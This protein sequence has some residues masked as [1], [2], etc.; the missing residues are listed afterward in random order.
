MSEHNTI[1]P[2]TPAISSAAEP[3]VLNTTNTQPPALYT[4]GLQRLPIQY[5]LSVGAVDDPMEQ[6]A[7][8][9]ADKI[10]RMPENNFIQRKC[11]H[12]EEEEKDKVR[13][14]PLAAFI[15]RKSGD[16]NKAVSNTVSEGIAATRGN[17]SAL[18]A[19]TQSFMENRFGTDF[20]NVNIHTDTPAVRLSAELGAK[21]FTIG[22]DI[23]FNEGK[24]SPESDSGK[25]LL[26]HELTHVIQQQGGAGNGMVQRA[27]VDDR[28]CAG[29]TDIETDINTLVNAEIAAARTA[30]GPAPLSPAAIVGL[31]RDVETRLG[32]GAVSPI[33]HFIEALPA[34]KRNLPNS[35]LTGNK[36]EGAGSANNFYRLQTLGLAHVVGSSAKMHGLC[37]GA[38]KLGH[39]FEEGF[40]YF[41]VAHRS[42][43]SVADAQSTGR[44]A[45]IGIQGLSST[46]VYSNADQAANLAGM[47]FYNDLLANPSGLTFSLASYITPQWNEQ[48]NPSFYESGVGTVVW[49]NLLRGN[50]QGPFT[51]AGGTGTPIDAKVTLAISSSG[52]VTGTYRWPAA[53]P[54]NTGVITAG[55]ITQN[56]TTV[57]GNLPGTA[58]VTASP[59]SSI[60]IDFDWRE[61]T[62]SGKGRWNSVNE[63]T[64]DGTWGIGASNTNGGTW[65]M[66]KI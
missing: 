24:F 36:Y 15:Q 32:D 6:E 44:A 47:Q 60:T 52:A 54:T 26:A 42:G 34:T 58:P 50:W 53:A 46:G 41:R 9:V 40:L 1:A 57:T 19:R 27:E 20:S 51:S 45:E 21:A 63:Q 2:A 25:H 13:L 55:V 11:A 64:L 48:T 33:E 43:G 30:A 5:Q 18:P 16:S 10:M 8:A 23:Y 7:D 28:S 31:L 65:H 61:G 17:G 22:N 12:C 49:N 39:F 29:L 3:V 59:V 14:K 66:V 38:D 56:T 62:A 37:I 4:N 35:S